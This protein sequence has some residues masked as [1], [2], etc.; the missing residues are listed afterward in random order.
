[1]SPFL[2]ASDEPQKQTYEQVMGTNPSHFSATGE[3]QEAAA[4]L[5]TGNNPVE[6]VSWNDAAEFCAKLSQ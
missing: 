4:N 5:E 3:G 2:L 1:M 6:M